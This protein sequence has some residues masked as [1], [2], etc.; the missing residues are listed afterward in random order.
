MTREYTSPKTGNEQGY[1]LL[2]FFFTHALTGTV[3]FKMCRYIFI[4]RQSNAHTILIKKNY[5]NNNKNNNS[6]S[7][8]N[9]NKCN[10][11]DG[12]DDDD[13]NDNSNNYSHDNNNNNSNNNNNYY[14]YYYLK[15]IY[16]IIHICTAVVDE[17]EE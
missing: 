8:N 10:I 7:S 15:F 4:T 12:G 17:S 16:E 6:S 5:N 13:D 14:Y 2:T 3:H 1:T 9:S 11:L